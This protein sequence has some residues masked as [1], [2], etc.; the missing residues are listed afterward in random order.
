MSGIIKKIGNHKKSCAALCLLVVLTAGL[1]MLEQYVLVVLLAGVAILNE[2]TIRKMKKQ[3]EPFGT[4][5]RTR[6]VDCLVIGDIGPGNAKT[7]AGEGTAVSIYL[8]G[9]TLAGAYEVL[10]HT[11]SILKEEGGNVVLAIKKK[12]LKI[13]RYSLFDAYF[14]HPVTINRLGLKKQKFMSRFPV[15]FAPVKSLMFLFGAGTMKNTEKHCDEEI[16]GFCS[17]RGIAVTVLEV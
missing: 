8:P 12:N 9:C 5:S 13:N 4:R 6:N 7:A 14:F 10:R 16:M 1:V 15:V 17:E 11:F 2:L 3:K